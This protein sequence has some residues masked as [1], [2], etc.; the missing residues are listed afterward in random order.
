MKLS[1][2]AVLAFAA[3]VLAKPKF[4]NSNFELEEGEPFT[5][6]WDNAEGPVTITVVQG[7]PGNLK[8]VS[9]ITTTGSDGEFTWT[10][11]GLPSGTY[12]FEIVDDTQE[13]NWSIQFPYTGTGTVTTTETPTSTAES[14]TST[15]E[16]S[17][18]SSSSETTETESST[19]TSEEASSTT[20]TT[21]TTEEAETS[22]RATSTPT[23]SPPDLNNG[24][25][26][27]SPLGFVLVTVA[28]LVFFN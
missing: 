12:A 5:L 6:T 17:T 24:Q 28:A 16:S 14:S 11:E 21:S 19:T 23:G 27:A 20:F 7:K 10:P 15:E 13:K 4:T 2:G 26:F 22:T 25:R 1:F 9:V 18:T 8:P 3:A